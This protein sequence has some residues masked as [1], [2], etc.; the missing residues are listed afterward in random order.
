VP[1]ATRRSYI[2]GLYEKNT[3]TGAVT[4]Y[5]GAL[6]RMIAMRKVPPGGGAGT[7]SYLLADHLGG[8]R[9]CSMPQAT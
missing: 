2:G 1:R 6:G 3:T 9:R 8:R 4:K 7:L 5:Y